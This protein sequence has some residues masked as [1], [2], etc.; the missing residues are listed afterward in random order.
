MEGCVATVCGRSH[1]GCI[2]RTA[3]PRFPVAGLAYQITWGIPFE[4]VASLAYKCSTVWSSTED[5]VI[6]VIRSTGRQRKNKCARRVVDV[7]VDFC[8]PTTYGKQLEFCGD[9]ITKRHLQTNKATA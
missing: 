2:L 3:I 9:A 8:L 4:V 5:A 1:Y 7:H 6:E